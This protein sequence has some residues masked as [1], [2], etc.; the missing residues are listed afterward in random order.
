MAMPF[1]IV[2]YSEL[3][4]GGPSGDR[5]PRP[6]RLAR[7]LARTIGVCLACGLLLPNRVAAQST[8]EYSPYRVTVWLAAEDSPELPES[9]R[10]R[11]RET[12]QDRAVVAAGAAWDVR[13]RAC[14]PALRHDVLTRIDA[15][16]AEDIARTDAARLP[17]DDKLIVLGVHAEPA[18]YRIQAR[19][20]DCR[21]RTW[22]PL[23]E[24]RVSQPRRL[25]DAAFQAVHEAFTPLVRI[26]QVR[27]RDVTVRLRAAGLILDETNPAHIPVE[28]ILRPVIRRNDR[29]GEPVEGGVMF[30]P[31]TFLV[32][33]Q[34]DGN[35]LA[36]RAHSGMFSLLA[37]RAS[38]RLQKFALLS[39]PPGEQST[40][41]IVR[42]G[43]GAALPGY[44][45]Y[46]QNPQTEETTLLG[47]T[48]WRGKLEVQ[49]E[50][51]PLQVL[52]VR[53]GGRLLAR[54]PIVPGLE[55][56]L[57]AEVRDDH[58]RLEAEGYVRGLQ[59]LVMDLVARRELYISRFSRH[60]QA[61][62][63]DQARALLERFDALPTRSDLARDL[64]Q[65]GQRFASSDLSDRREQAQIDQMFKETQQLL[66]RF[67]DPGTGREL[68]AELAEA[69]GAS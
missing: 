42:R 55:P 24:H 69:R 54:L 60:V 19:E 43:D 66:S 2:P 47:T 1:R 28:A 31:W 61:E 7:V 21:T 44:E 11:L 45:I 5:P 58:R 38:A 29:M 34:Q 64:V 49:Q 23:V 51:L 20:L 17:I 46:R 9:L 53:N 15:L 35:I 62:D 67:L 4:Q 36:C 40:V 16:T 41:R 3:P 59:N 27:N 37:V 12:I 8:W 65:Q 50:G 39:K 68:A 32:V 57:T 25:A 22:Q 26:E 63:F 18:G 56:E 48:D 10:V 33:Q 6:N 52:Y 14:P 13:V 30:V